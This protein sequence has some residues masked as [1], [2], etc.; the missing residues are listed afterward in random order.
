[1]LY[2]IFHNCLK[3]QPPQLPFL[4]FGAAK[5]AMLIVAEALFIILTKHISESGGWQ[6]SLAD[7]ACCTTVL[8]TTNETMCM[9]VV[10]VMCRNVIGDDR[11]LSTSLLSH[12]TQLCTLIQALRTPVCR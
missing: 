1:M 4:S 10:K 5:S 11:V 6:V 9:C 12:T 2:T 7:V 8:I 3:I